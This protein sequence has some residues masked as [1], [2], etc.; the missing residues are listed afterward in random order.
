MLVDFGS[1][2]PIERT[3][4]R[5]LGDGFHA[6]YAAPELQGATGVIDGRAD[7]F[8]A[9]VV[10]YEMLTGQLPYQWG[11]KAGRPEFSHTFCSDREITGYAFA[12]LV[13]SDNAEDIARVR[14]Q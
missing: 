3:A 5:E 11:G 7:Q 1:A 6:S 2:W 9:S 10:L 14:I 13:L 12:G 8:S 4:R